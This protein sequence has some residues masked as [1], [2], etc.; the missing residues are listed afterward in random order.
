MPMFRYISSQNRPSFS[1]MEIPFY[2]QL[3]K[4]KIE[5]FEAEEL[6]VTGGKIFD[7]LKGK[8]F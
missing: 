4:N 8:D 2:G 6:D 1:L 7:Y 3:R 5:R